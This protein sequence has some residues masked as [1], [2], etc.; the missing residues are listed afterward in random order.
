MTRR[1]LLEVL[2]VER[3]A[4]GPRPPQ[5]ARCDPPAPIT[6]EQA[7]HN[8]QVLAEALGTDAKVIDFNERRS[9]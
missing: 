6:P 4:P 1:E 9:A 8:L 5:F 3:H 7:E 2:A